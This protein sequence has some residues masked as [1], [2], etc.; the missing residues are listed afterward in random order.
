MSGLDGRPVTGAGDHSNLRAS[1]DQS[2]RIP[3]RVRKGSIAHE[4]GGFLSSL[5]DATG[6]NV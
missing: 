4:P 5:G 1:A 6:A 3:R 2:V